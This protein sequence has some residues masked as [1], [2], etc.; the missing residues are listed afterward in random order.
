[1]CNM[2]IQTKLNLKIQLINNN[3]FF[4]YFKVADQFSVNHFPSVRIAV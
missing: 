1:M 3:T 4:C 2:T